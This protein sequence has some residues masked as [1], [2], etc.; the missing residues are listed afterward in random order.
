MNG[1]TST[2]PLSSAEQIFSK[3]LELQQKLQAAAPNYEHLLHTIHMMLQKDP[4][5]THLLSEEQIGVVVAGLCK[6]KNIVIAEPQKLSRKTT[7]STGK[8]LADVELGD[9]D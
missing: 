3:I 4:D 7:T 9:L 8:K 2:S 6:R 1:L 5:L